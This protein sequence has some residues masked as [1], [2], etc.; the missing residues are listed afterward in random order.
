MLRQ[1]VLVAVILLP[2][3]IVLIILGGVYFAAFITLVMA[4]ASWEFVQLMRSSGS[5]PAGW[6]VVAGTVLFC[7]TRAWTSFELSPFSIS[8]V[9]LAV[10]V[11]H[12]LDYE[13]GALFPASDFAVSLTGIFYLGWIGA[14]LISLRNMDQ[15]VY[16]LSISLLSVMF[17][18]SAAYFIGRRWGRTRLSPRLSPKKTWEGYIAGVVFGSLV[19]ALATWATGKW[20]VPQAGF[21]WVNGLI[22]GFL[23]SSLTTLGDLTES[24][25]KRQ[26][27]VKDSGT[28]LPGHGGV[29]DRI[30]SWLWAG[31]IAYYIISLLVTHQIH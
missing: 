20:L 5:K 8:L 28:L 9:I 18:D 25:F 7:G 3:G 29:F 10:A 14:Y 6:I 17:A 4:L 1:R 30:D 27:G 13:K 11:Y 15:G 26:V 16:W 23:L 12:L 31:V 2:I 22:L 19:G 21:T 24:M